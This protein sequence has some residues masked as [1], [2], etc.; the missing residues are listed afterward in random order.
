MTRTTLKG[1]FESAFAAPTPE[2]AASIAAEAVE[3]V[4]AEG[5]TST[6]APASLPTLTD[7]TELKALRDTKQNGRRRA[8]FGGFI[9]DEYVMLIV[10]A[11]SY[12]SINA[13]RDELAA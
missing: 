1:M 5:V 4:E 12:E 2:E 6:D 13:V 7:V 8:T 11:D 9:G 3:R 10:T